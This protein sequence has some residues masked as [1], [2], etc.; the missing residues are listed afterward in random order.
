MIKLKMTNKM[1]FLF[2]KILVALFFISFKLQAQDSSVLTFSSFYLQVVQNHPLAKQANLLTAAAKAELLA[3]RGAFDPVIST[4][5]SN[6]QTD[7]NNSYTYFEPQLKV[8]TLIGVDLKAGFDQS[9]G[10]AVNSENAK[11]KNI[12]GQYTQQNVEYGMLYA[13][14]SVPLLRGLQTDARRVTLRQ[15]QVLQGLNE[16]E[17]IKLINKLFLN[18]AKDYWEW[19]LAFEK[20]RLM[21]FNFTLAETRFN[22]IRNRIIGGEEKPIDSIEALIELKRRET[23]LIETEVEFKNTSLALSNYLWSEKNEALQLKENVVPS[24][25][26]IEINTFGNDSVQKLVVYAEN[27]HPELLKLQFKSKQLQFDRKLAIENI[28]PQLNI[29]YYPFQTFTK[30]T[31]DN[32]NNNFERQYKFG[33]TFYSSLFLRKERGKL[34]Q[35]NIKI[36]NIDFET[37]V[38]KREI[39]N[40]LLANFN[41]LKNL[42]Q[43]I[44]IQT[45]L[46]KNSFSLRNAE[47]LRFENGESSLFLVNMRERSL[48]EAQIKQAEINSK[49]AKAKVQLQWSSGIKLF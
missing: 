6:K 19:Q 34:Q 43:I 23:I 45:E 36:K 48:I 32:I 39:V 42:E 14:L 41:N 5:Y 49:Y 11:Y 24:S 31:N 2:F 17:K 7:G 30:G 20:L 4:N 28:K 18:A 12:N 8:P 37:K 21:K 33:A 22:F 38:V 10:F 47:Q 25:I 27:Y 44:E 13:G 35:A 40:D 26:G 9:D 1:K 3:A 46:V 16:A 29:E 15:A